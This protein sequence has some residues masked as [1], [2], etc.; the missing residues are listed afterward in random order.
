MPVF[1]CPVGGYAKEKRQVGKS[2]L[3]Y[4]KA[5]I[6][7]IGLLAETRGAFL[8]ELKDVHSAEE[9]AA[10]EQANREYFERAIPDGSF[11]AWITMDGEKVA[12]TSGIC[13]YDVP[14]H[15]KIPHGKV[16]YI[17]NMYTKEEYRGRGIATELFRRITQ[18]AIDRSVD[19]ITLNATDVGKPLYQKYGFE[20][21]NGDMA[22]Y[23][24]KNTI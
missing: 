6:E 5:G 3:E 10:A 18:E 17:M 13:F 14:P 24:K 23:V 7:D 4:R 21:V 20:D 8:V 1:F 9:R 15:G 19:K 2:M 12:G 11:I 22:F 16:A